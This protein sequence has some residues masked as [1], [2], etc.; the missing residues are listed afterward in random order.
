MAT[1][2]PKTPLEEYD[3][4]IAE[5]RQRARVARERRRAS[6]LQRLSRLSSTEP[7][8]QERDLRARWRNEDREEDRRYTLSRE[9]LVKRLKATDDRWA[10]LRRREEDLEIRSIAG[11]MDLYRGVLR[12]SGKTPVTVA[13]KYL[14]IRMER[15]GPE[16]VPL[17]AEIDRWARDLGVQIRWTAAVVNG[18]AWPSR[19]EIEVAPIRSHAAFA[20]VG[21]ELGHVARPCRPDHRRV[22]RAN[23]IG[24]LCVACE[25][26]AWRWFIDAASVF[27]HEM[28][29]QMADALPTY[30][31]YA[32]EAEARQV[33]EMCSGLGYGRERLRRAM[34]DQKGISR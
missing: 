29:A 27:S 13:R 20:V 26:H 14:R 30:R 25:V 4:S 34:R 8:R 15:S 2:K 9:A 18:Y 33:D 22:P 5:S 3:C 32:T 7:Q 11:A 23:G 12:G 1:T 17:R 10:D 16:I 6:E 24:T 31:P 28:F 19:R 21:H